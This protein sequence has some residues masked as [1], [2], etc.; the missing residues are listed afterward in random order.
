MRHKKLFGTSGIRGYAENLETETRK[1]YVHLTNAFSYTIT[2]AFLDHVIQQRG[3]K[4]VIV[5]AMDMRPSSPRIKDAIMQALIDHGWTPSYQG[6]VPTPAL[7]CYVK[8]KRCAGGIMI[9][10]SHIPEN[11][12]GIKFFLEEGEI[13]KNN[14]KKI[15][16]LY[17]DL[18]QFTPSVKPDQ[19]NLEFGARDL[20]IDMLKKHARKVAQKRIKPF[21][22]I[23]VVLDTRSSCQAFI[24]PKVLRELGAEV[25]E[26]Q[27]TGTFTSVDTEQTTGENTE[28]KQALAKNM[29]HIGV[30]YDGDGDRAMFYRR[31][32]KMVM[33]D[34]ICTLIARN[35]EC[36]VA[37][38]NVSSLID[39]I[40]KP[41][42]RT[43][44][45]SP[46]VVAAMKSELEEGR[47][48]FGF[49]SNGGCIFGEHLL[50]RDAGLPTVEVIAMIK[51]KPFITVLREL[52]Q[53]HQVKDKFDCPSVYNDFILEKARAFGEKFDDQF[54][55]I[56]EMDGVKVQLVNHAWVLFRP[57]SNAPEFRVFAE[58]KTEEKAE[59][60]AD[61]GLQFARTAME[62]AAGEMR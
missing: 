12:N 60:L 42:Q 57:S 6:V 50:T 20:Y 11:M 27:D 59:Y 10:G 49:E 52:P 23:K 47:R 24:M 3:K 43:K 34:V 17:Y 33:P 35:F 56:E 53:F 18:E 21:D 41:V 22:G 37:P 16:E 55:T 2:Q 36:V 9:T 15:E 44:V 58:A 30:G 26:L 29:A 46:Y 62:E 32:G 1:D 45:G 54:E 4:G 31:D 5:V 19:V 7:A 48:C 39:C 38:V 25:F 61:M 8:Q 28:M 40:G 51:E 13:L 14:E